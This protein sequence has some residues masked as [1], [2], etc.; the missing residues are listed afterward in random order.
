MYSQLKQ[1]EYVINTLYPGKTDGWFIEAGADNGIY[2]SNTK[3][4]EELGWKGLCIEP[5][6]DV[7]SDLVKNRKCYTDN[8]A[9]YNVSG[10]SVNFR[11]N[12]YS[13]LSGIESTLDKSR[14]S[15]KLITV[16]TSTLTDLLD[17]YNI[18]KKIQ[19]FSLDIEGAEYIALQ[20]I[21]WQKY[22][23]GVLNIEHNYRD[24][25]S[26]IRKYI[27]SKGYIYHRED[28]WDDWYI[29]KDGLDTFK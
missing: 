20:G 15:D 11:I 16:Q 24:D 29:H 19:Y 25:R 10:Q 8:S 9:L 26:T 21:D 5:I 4:L 6:P 23:F 12:D 1:D 7:Y 28:H 13:L 17:K 22:Q 2:L 18:P 27:E 3:A 14:L